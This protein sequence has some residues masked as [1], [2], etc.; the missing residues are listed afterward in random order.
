MLYLHSCV[1]YSKQ[2]GLYRRTIAISIAITIAIAIA[3]SKGVTKEV[4]E[5]Y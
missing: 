2:V 3:I 1:M 5:S 4:F